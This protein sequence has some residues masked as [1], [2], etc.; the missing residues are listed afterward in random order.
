MIFLM[1]CIAFVFLIL[2][3][4]PAVA[5]RI[6]QV[7]P[8]LWEYSHNLVIPGLPIPSGTKRTEC[9]SPKEARHSLSDLLGEFS[10]DA[11]CTVSNLKDTL[12]TVEFDLACRPEINGVKITSTGKAAFKY[13][14]TK[15]S[16][17]V[18]GM[19]HINGGE[20]IFVVG[21]GT[22]HRIGLCP[23]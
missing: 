22:A 17:N 11:G 9:I 20:P 1:R 15:I 21:D 18:S 16:G 12:N 5:D 8:G 13:S 6:I 14:R 23:K 2:L 10:G 4:Q 19:M 7:E 3:T